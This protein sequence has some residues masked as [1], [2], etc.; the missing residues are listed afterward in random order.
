MRRFLAILALLL[1]A[2]S[3]S[4]LIKPN[5]ATSVITYFDLRDTADGTGKTALDVTTFD[6]QYVE[7]GAAP[8]AKVDC[9]SLGSTNA[10]WDDNEAFEIDA[11]DQPGL[12]RVDWPN[13]AFDGGVG[14]V[15]V[16]TVKCAG[17]FTK[18]ITVELSPSAN[19]TEWEGN[20]DSGAQVE[21][22]ATDALEADNLDHLFAAVD[23]D[24]ATTVADTSTL[25]FLL[26]S[27]NVS[28]YSR[29]TD[30][31]EALA[32]AVGAA[33][34]ALYVP[35]ASSAI[36]T[37]NQDAGTWASCAADN[38]TRWTIGDENGTNTIDVTCEFNMGESRVAA[39]L[40][41]NGYFN[42]SGGGGYVVQVYAWDYTAGA[43][44]GISGGTTD[45]QLADRSTDKD[46]VFAVPAN[47]TD[48]V[49]TAGEVKIQFR[50]T[51][52]ATAGGDVLYLD[53]VAVTGLASAALSPEAVASAVWQH[54]Y[55]HTVA[56]HTSRYTGHVWYV[57]AGMSDDEGG[58]MTPV[59]AFQKIGTAITAASAGDRIVI[60]AGSYVEASIDI[61]KAGL[62]LWGEHGTILTGGGSGTAL[63]ISAS[64]VLVNGVWATP[65]AAQ[66]GFDIGPDATCHRTRL[67]DCI[68]YSTGGTGFRV[69]TDDGR[70]TFERCEARGYTTAGFNLG[71]PAPYLQDCLAIAPH[72]SST[73]GY[74]L[75][76]AA[77][78]RG[79][80]HH[81]RS[82]NNGT[83]SI[84]IVAGADENVFHVCTDS[85]T[86]GAVTDGGTDNALRNMLDVDNEWA[87]ATRT[88]TGTQTFNLT[89]NI[90]G[91]LSGSAGDLLKISGSADAANN[92][93][94]VFATDFATN[95]D[96]T[97]DTW[98]IDLDNV[99]G[100]LDA[101]EI[102]ADAITNAKIADDVEVDVKTIET[103][104]ATTYLEGRTLAAAAYF[105]FGDDT[106]ANVTAVSTVA[107]VNGLAANV[108]DASA[109]K[110]DAATEIATATWTMALPG[111]FAAGSAG[112]H[113]GDWKDGE[114]LDLI[115][116]A[117]G[118]GGGAIEYPYTLTSDVGGAPIANAFVWVTTDEEGLHTHTRG[119]TNASGIV[120]FQLD[121]GTYY[122]WRSHPSFTFTNPDEETV[123]P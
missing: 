64:N 7:E 5:G 102:G 96:T 60:K 8:S 118:L 27:A 18:H 53:Y 41:V 72:G 44:L 81:C 80:L 17:V 54:D 68:S 20:A 87:R 98:T 79:M 82:I 92:A 16:L 84:L 74:H 103:A 32:N 104:D 33:V 56:L 91:N 11:T 23:T 40:D 108:I 70:A 65:G 57:D 78:D 76:N 25:G 39:Q 24:L 62:E 42:R 69:G 47:C 113:L 3:A 112:R 71:G 101:G 22:E 9:T 2:S 49:T 59:D 120:T 121:A 61:T 123:S 28:N 95:Y 43:W 75:S 34:G 117:G 100:T 51:R 105:L 26:T 85:D 116:D 114:R 93:E 31:Q 106:V 30:S 6:L 19:V 99:D 37:G 122:F 46:Y 88:L 86:C 94:I 115:L 73:I 48:T 45:T 83:N 107:T 10:A 14:K 21:A 66:V 63:E 97:A 4:A 77:C 89:G 111:A 109:L 50:S 36:T 15:V 52:G 1:L 110:A 35:D 90:T 29:T 13:A 58:G 67:V 12:Y 55:G 119:Y 38:G